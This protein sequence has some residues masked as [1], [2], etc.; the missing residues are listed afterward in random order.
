MI[1][2]Q[3]AGDLYYIASIVAKRAKNELDM[4]LLLVANGVLCIWKF[5]QFGVI[6]DGSYK[7]IADAALLITNV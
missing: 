1:I 6:L 4:I 5:L 7:R 3:T 2:E